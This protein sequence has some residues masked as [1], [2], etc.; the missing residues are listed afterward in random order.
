[1]TRAL[2]SILVLFATMGA[3]A[4]TRP[5][6]PVVTLSCDRQLGPLAID[7]IALGQGG[8]SAD[9]MFHSRVA[10]VRALHPGL[11]R[12]FVQEYYDL[13][14]ERGRLHCEALDRSVD[15]I[16]RAGSSPLMCLCFKPRVLFPTIDERQVEP[17]DYEAWEKLVFDLVRHYSQRHPG[18]V[19]YWEIGNEVDIGEIGGCPYLFQPDAYVRYYRHTAAAILR[20]DPDA[21]VGGPALA[22][23]RSPI[24]PALL[25]ACERDKVPLH[26]VS[27]HIYSSSP[28]TIRAT[29]EYAKS[30]LKEHPG[31]KPETI[32]DEWNMDLYDP[33][34]DPAFQPCFV[35]ET[36][37]QMKEAGL[38]W[39]CY[40]HV[41]D[42]HVD[43]REFG[44]FFSPGGVAFMARWWNRMPQADGLFDF[45]DHV[46]PAYFAFKLLSRLTGQRLHLDCGA[47][48]L[49]G[50][51]TYDERY[52]IYNLLI[53]NFS[54]QPAEF[55]LA[56]EGLPGAM[57]MRQ[58]KLDAV[59]PSDDENARLHPESPVRVP[60]S[61]PRQHVR[62]EPFGVRFWSFE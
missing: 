47:S 3:A 5:A 62:I 4:Q 2:A 23:V 48:G 58:L 29:I 8:L 38:D 22:S 6:V 36:A 16:I 15:D 45:Q 33:P 59:A 41:R 32:L 53:W 26:F 52:H 28:T 42:Y 55:E 11:I 25:A 12:L 18:R 37:L 57:L 46:R 56:V 9:P 10:E 60:A 51:A 40:Y 19:R 20:A 13:L 54:K 17:N 31:L 34:M 30:L 21:R 35:L 24:L 14:P 39:S 27:W 61:P 49:H 50:M 1:M 43:E 7:H 44:R